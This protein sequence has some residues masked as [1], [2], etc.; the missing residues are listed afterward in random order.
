MERQ[1]SFKNEQMVTPAQKFWLS[2][3]SNFSDIILNREGGWGTELMLVKS[4]S[5]K[6]VKKTKSESGGVSPGKALVRQPLEPGASGASFSVSP[7]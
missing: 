1:W 6:N 4:L 7:Q 2:T 5:G 3:R